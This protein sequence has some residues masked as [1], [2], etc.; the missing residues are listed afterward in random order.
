MSYYSEQS[1]IDQYIEMS[2]EYSGAAFMKELNR[3]LSEGASVLELGI[4]EG[5]D[6]ALLKE[7]GFIP[8]GSDSS[9]PFLDRWNSA[10]SS[11]KALF[12]DAIE[13]EIDSQYDC[14]YSNKVLQHLH[15]EELSASLEKQAEKLN[16]GGILFH[17][18]WYGE[19]SGDMGGSFYMSHTEESL[20]P[21]IPEC[22]ELVELTRYTEMDENDSCWIV[23]QKRNQK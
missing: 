19:D 2:K 14:F 20:T 15:S 23:L 21:L 7:A 18:I 3:Y 8:T 11:E 10:H 13:L 16:D 9:Q 12:V 1:N 5:K 6:Q 17:A 22:L 4:G